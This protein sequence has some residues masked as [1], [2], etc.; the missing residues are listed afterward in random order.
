MAVILNCRSQQRDILFAPGLQRI[1][2]HPG[3]S[4][5]GRSHDM[6]NTLDLQSSADPALEALRE[7]LDSWVTSLR[8]AVAARDASR[9]EA[10]FQPDATF[11]DL[12][13][14]SWDFRNA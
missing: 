1:S 14:R 8:D 11:R 7:V 12:L 10:L 4:T 6:T 5:S 9:V 13:A 2:V 3:T